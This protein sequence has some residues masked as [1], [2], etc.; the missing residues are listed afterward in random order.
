M[1]AYNVGV[2]NV[3]PGREDDFVA[4]WHALGEWAIESGYEF[5]GTLLRDGADPGRFVSIDVWRSAE[6]LER[7]R[8]DGGY[9]D[10]L[11]AI[12]A[13]IADYDSRAYEL[14]M[15]VS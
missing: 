14:V 12:E 9:R 1:S 4:A 13:A 8:D 7:H 10:R 5:N 2:W 15:Q 11:A 6:Q 3:K